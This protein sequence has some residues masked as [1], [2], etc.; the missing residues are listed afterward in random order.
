MIFRET[1]RAI[2]IYDT[3]QRFVVLFFF[4]SSSRNV[5]RARACTRR[6]K[7]VRAGRFEMS[8]NARLRF[9]NAERRVCL[10]PS[11]V[12]NLKDYNSFF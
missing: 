6:K 3:R 2:D 10:S 9:N 8:C 5:Q 7:C 1:A 12:Y 4:S 11:V